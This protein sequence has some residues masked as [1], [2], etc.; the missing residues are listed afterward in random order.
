MTEDLKFNIR[1]S[2]GPNRSPQEIAEFYKNFDGWQE[3][4]PKTDNTY[5]PGSKYYKYEI[6][7]G[8]PFIPN[9]SRRPINKYDKSTIKTDLQGDQTDYFN[10]SS[11]IKRNLFSINISRHTVNKNYSSF[12]NHRE[13]STT[14]HSTK[15]KFM[16][17]ISKTF[18]T[19]IQSLISILTT[20]STLIKSGMEHS[21]NLTLM[22]IR[23][24]TNWVHLATISMVHYDLIIITNLRKLFGHC[25]EINKPN[26]F[27]KPIILSSLI[28]G[29]IA[30][31]LHLYSPMDVNIWDKSM[32]EF[33]LS[34]F[35]T[36]FNL[37]KSICLILS[38]TMYFVLELFT[39]GLASSMVAIKIFGQT[40]FNIFNNI[41][42]VVDSATKF[43]SVKQNHDYL[44]FDYNILARQILATEEFQRLIINQLNITKIDLIRIY[45]Q[46]FQET[47]KNQINEMNSENLKWI[48]DQLNR[49][50]NILKDM[51]DKTSEQNK[52]D[53]KNLEI[54]MSDLQKI[55]ADVINNFEE[56]KAASMPSPVNIESSLNSTC[57][58]ENWFSITNYIEKYVNM[59]M[60]S[61][62]NIYDA[63]KTGRA[64]FAL[65]SAGAVVLGTRCTVTKS[66]TAA[67]TMFG[68][69]LWYISNGPRLAIQPGVYPGQC[70]AFVGAKGFLVLKLSNTIFINGFTIEHLP[71]SLSE[72]GSIKSAPKDFSV[73]GL[74]NELDSNGTLLGR[75][76]FRVE[77][78]SLQYFK[79]LPKKDPFSIVE[80]R[81][82]S[83]H[84]HDEYTCL[85]R[86]RVHGVLA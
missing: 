62:L 79:A 56:H 47:I 81:I 21:S 23:K 65:E 61:T 14:V 51:Y 57:T 59:T 43:N 22:S 53:I 46:E 20:V 67:L 15:L 11:H 41:N 68:I 27:L 32:T 9:M 34:P 55:V 66:S 5:S 17:L 45:D 49:Q 28:L 7:P 60:K 50:K 8:I 16:S 13:I 78:P 36:I 80:L 84:G 54:K 33:I 25:F 10:S 29:L 83:N 63:D 72:D 2:K 37:V 26:N 19:F 18:N 24:V 12:S 3:I 71:K 48:N 76:Q 40:F 38:S 77:G 73:W 75:N 39:V 4:L 1:P 86:I 6:S 44:T 69:P 85:Y 74:Q 58:R 52:L 30:G 42:T 82:E 35:L 31:V 70:W 64:D